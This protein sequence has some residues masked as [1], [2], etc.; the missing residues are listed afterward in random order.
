MNPSHTPTWS[1]FNPLDA[2]F[3]TDPAATVATAH[4]QFPV[5]YQP[6]LN[7]WVL[8]KYA[9]ITKALAD[10][11]TFSSRAVGR[12]PVP[13]DL[14]ALVP[15]YHSDDIIIALDPPEHTAARAVMQ[16]GFA[17]HVVDLM[18]PA[19][20]RISSMLIDRLADRGECNF[21]HDFA[22]EYSLGVIMEV[23]DLPIDRAADYR[24]WSEALIALLVPKVTNSGA[25]VQ[26]SLSADEIRAH[27]VALAEANDFFDE[28]V[29]SREQSTNPDL[30]TAML[31]VRDADGQLI[32]PRGAIIRH[33][34]SLVTAG[35]DTSANLISHLVLMLTDNPDQRAL[36][37]QDEAL[38]SNAID[39]GLRR[40]GSASMIFR[41]TTREVELGGVQIP[42]GALVCV[43]LPGGN[44]DAEIFPDPVR[45]DVRRSNASRHLGFGHGLH[46]CIGRALVKIEARVALSQLYRRLPDLRIDRDQPISYLPNFQASMLTNITARWSVPARASVAA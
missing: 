4:A 21:I 16:K 22:Y 1:G 23:L 19:A 12:L 36:L 2:A 35:H 28:I 44:L 10:Y 31:A 11:R 9:D 17:K 38:L 8:T 27:W 20:E 32:I 46:A 34:L 3:L 45:F 15:D 6:D 40:R 25:T 26:T 24:R 13:D 33:I 5:F 43:L 14:A 39:E 42:Q 41:I 18:V 37:K 7:L 29:R 30:V